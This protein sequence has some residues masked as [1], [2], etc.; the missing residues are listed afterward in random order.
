M[1]PK[2]LK[3]VLRTFRW[4][5]CTHNMPTG[6]MLGTFCKHVQTTLGMFLVG[7]FQTHGRVSCQLWTR[8]Y[9]WAHLGHI[10]RLHSKC[11]QHVPAGQMPSKVSQCLQ[12]TQHVP[13]KIQ[14]PSPPVNLQPTRDGWCLNIPRR[15][16]DTNLSC[17]RP[18]FDFDFSFWVTL[19]SSSPYANSYA[20][21]RQSHDLIVF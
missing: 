8:C 12:C 17:S 14:I 3:K 6:H 1:Y 13:T 15:C 10:T 7:T 20:P 9:Q 16:P 21:R 11:E 2:K 4:N 18:A 19:W 5:A